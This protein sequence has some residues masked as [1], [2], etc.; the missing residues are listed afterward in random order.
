MKQTSL[1][2]KNLIISC[3]TKVS[4]IHIDLIWKLNRTHQ[5]D[6][7]IYGRVPFHCFVF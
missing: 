6:L 1:I 2:R 7:A 4:R 5:E 3:K